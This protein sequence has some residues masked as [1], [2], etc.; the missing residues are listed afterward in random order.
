MQPRRLVQ[1]T[2]L[3]LAIALPL[4]QRYATV[5]AAGDRETLLNEPLWRFFGAIFYPFGDPEAIARFIK[6]ILGWTLSFG[7]LTISD[8]LVAAGLRGLTPTLLLSILPTLLLTLLVGRYFC[9]WICPAGFLSEL[10]AG[11]RGFLE[12][13]GVRLPSWRLDPRIRYFLLGLGT[14]FSA[15]TGIQLFAYFYPPAL[16]GRELYMALNV[17]QIGTG[18][19]LLASVGLL[20]LV[21]MPRVWCHSLCPGGA[22]YSLVSRFRLVRIQRQ[23]AQCISCN[24]CVSACAF[25]QSPMTD[26]IG[27]DCTSCG[28]C[29]MACPTKALV[30]TLP[31][32]GAIP[33]SVK[34]GQA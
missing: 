28:A 33:S 22:F 16:L 9:G 10:I 12:R 27:A 20:E 19:V 25:D 4:L 23:A 17:A 18:S 11:A 13:H 7:G 24:Q 8:P 32:A 30:V 31:I 1:A 29:V 21:A 34:E 2:V 14:L 3:L 15:L 6:G 26:R 5:R